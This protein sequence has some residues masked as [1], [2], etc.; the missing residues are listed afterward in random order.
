MIWIITDLIAEAI[1][2]VVYIPAIAL[3]AVWC[4]ACSLVAG[5][6]RGLAGVKISG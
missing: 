1:Y 3:T 4:L 6:K 5:V 2:R